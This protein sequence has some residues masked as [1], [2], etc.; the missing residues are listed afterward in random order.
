MKKKIL[1]IGGYYEDCYEQVIYHKVDQQMQVAANQFQ[2]KLIEGFKENNYDVDV[3]SLPFIKHFTF[4]NKDL[5]FDL[6]NKDSENIKYLKFFNVFG[7]KNISRSRALKKE[8]SKKIKEGYFENIDFIYIYS[9]HTPFLSFIKNFKKVYS[10]I[11]ILLNILDL[12]E[13]MGKVNASLIRKVLKKVDN[14]TFKKQI[15]KIDGFINIT[16][17]ISDYI[18]LDPKKVMVIEG[19]S[20]IINHENSSIDSSKK[21][22]TYTGGINKETSS[23]MKLV[24]SFLNVDYKD[25]IL[26][27]AGVGN[28]S[29]DLK[30]LSENHENIR[31]LG[32]LTHEETT[33]LQRNSWILVNPRIPQ[34]HTKYSFPS[35]TMEYLSSGSIVISARLEGIPIEYEDHLVYYDHNISEDLTKKLLENLQLTIKEKMIIGK[36]NIDFLNNCKTKKIITA[37]IIEFVGDLNHES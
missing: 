5:F 9:A 3:I 13:F 27:I 14:R 33:K 19:I 24:E 17:Y 31:Y 29:D 18:R 22:V 12:P 20:E 7:I 32:R 21:L 28:A 34:E 10:D 15:K 16:K 2:K 36:R 30:K 35:K 37:K 1:F 26:C 23:I 6:D 4:K 8:V 11:P 25:A